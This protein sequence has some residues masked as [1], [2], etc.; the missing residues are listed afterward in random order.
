MTMR[1]AKVALL[2]ALASVAVWAQVN[3]GQQKPEAGLPFTM[4]QRE[5]PFSYVISAGNQATFTYTITNTS[6]LPQ[7]VTI[8]G[9]MQ[10]MVGLDARMECSRG[11]SRNRILKDTGMVSL[12]MDLVETDLPV[13]H[14]AEA[15]GYENLQHIARYFRKE[16]NLSLVAYRKLYGSK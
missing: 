3:V 6:R 7:T 13:S 4:N 10:N 15:L 2:F 14:I 5:V 12:V 9:I 16:K 8:D 1:L 11:M